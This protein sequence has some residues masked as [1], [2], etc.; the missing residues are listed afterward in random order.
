M[1]PSPHRGHVANER[2][3]C[4]RCIKNAKRHEELEKI[5]A[6]GKKNNLNY[7]EIEKELN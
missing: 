4:E 2:E 3:P 7:Q 5:R 1:L 6:A